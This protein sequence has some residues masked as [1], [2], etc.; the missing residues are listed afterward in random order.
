M[1]PIQMVVSLLAVLMLGPACAT[2][3]MSGDVRAVESSLAE[4]ARLPELTLPAFD[5]PDDLPAE[6]DRLVEKPLTDDSAVRVALLSNRDARAALADIGIARGDYL[7]AGL[8][9]NPELDL[10]VRA[11]GGP[12]PVQLDIGLELSISETVLAPLRASVAEAQLEAAR[13]RATGFLLELAWQTRLAFFEAQ[14]AQQRLDLRLR[15]FA[16]QQASYATAVELHRVGNLPAIDLANE[17]AAV[18]LS[19]LQ[20]AE[21]ENALLDAREAL[22]RKLGLA[23]AR[24]GFSIAGTLPTPKDTPVPTD[25]E[26]KAITASLELLE[27]NRRAEAASRKVGLA[28]TEGWL[29]HLTAGFHGERDADLWELGAHVGIGLPVFDRAQGRQLSAQS[30][31]DALRA[32]AESTAIGIRSVTRS[33]LN[34]VESA[35]RRAR[36]FAERLVPARQKQLDETVLQYNAMTV[37]V[38]QVLQVQRGVTES[39]LAQVDATLDYWKARAGLDLLLAGRSTPLSAGMALPSSTLSTPS[40]QGG[41]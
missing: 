33:T 21:S 22:T 36:H 24:T 20:V 31:Y 13:L 4:R 18:E 27:F 1:T 12:Q 28:T 17:L 19:R 39:A 11:P 29:P 37:G 34:R 41:H 38:F 32:R 8:I 25:A 26:A 7:Q 15:A 2:S 40:A 16:S 23:G 6:V 5:A 35:G 9:P 3:R 14:A 30:E 10:A